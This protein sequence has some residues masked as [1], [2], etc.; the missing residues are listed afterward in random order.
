[1]LNDQRKRL[2][3]IALNHFIGS[4]KY[5]GGVNFLKSAGFSFS[6]FGIPV[7]LA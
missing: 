4:E 3:K 6:Q 1:M 2:F 7:I 5:G